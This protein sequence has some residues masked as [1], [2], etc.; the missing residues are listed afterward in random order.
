MLSWATIESRYSQVL[1]VMRARDYVVTLLPVARL[2]FCNT[3]K[4]ICLLTFC[5]GQSKR[6]PTVHTWHGKTSL[7]YNPG[8]LCKKLYQIL[9]CDCHR[10]PRLTF[11]AQESAWLSM[12]GYPSGF[13]FKALVWLFDICPIIALFLSRCTCSNSIEF[14]HFTMSALRSFRLSL[15]S[16]CSKSWL[17]R[18][19][20]WLSALHYFKRTAIGD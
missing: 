14:R 8:A 9:N 1:M 18:A 12:R 17:A 11:Q 6:H 3:C 13:I 16:W 2:M 10:Q 20:S 4:T 5:A 7:L 19:N 15:C